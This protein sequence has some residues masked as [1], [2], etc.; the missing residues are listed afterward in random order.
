MG[1]IYSGNGK[2]DPGTYEKA[3]YVGRQGSTINIPDHGSFT[4]IT[5]PFIPDTGIV[6]TDNVNVDSVTLKANKKYSGAAE[7]LINSTNADLIQAELLVT[8]VAGFPTG[9]IVGRAIKQ[10]TSGF[11]SA[12]QLKL[13]FSIEPT[14]D[15]NISLA[16]GTQGT[17][18][19]V[20]HEVGSAAQSYLRFIVKEHIVV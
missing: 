14:A 9:N 19:S 17:G 8:S 13:E 2:V 5:T 20:P 1:I 16:L 10:L 11:M 12:A 6:V 18:C 15:I 3:I 4:Y 7:C